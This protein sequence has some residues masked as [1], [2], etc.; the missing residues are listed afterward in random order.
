MLPP[1]GHVQK[2]FS[3]DNSRKPWPID[4]TLMCGLVLRRAMSNSLFS[5]SYVCICRHP[6][7]SGYF[8]SSRSDMHLVLHVFSCGQRNCNT[9]LPHLLKLSAGDFSVTELPCCR[10]VVNVWNFGPNLYALYY[11]WTSGH[12]VQASISNIVYVYSHVR[13]NNKIV[14]FIV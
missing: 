3:D 13:A 2:P 8:R 6:V 14:W 11:N 7:W 1:G 9:E 4:S 12:R 5:A 10:Y